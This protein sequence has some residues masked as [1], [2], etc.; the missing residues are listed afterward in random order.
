M[1]NEKKAVK[2]T[3]GLWSGALCLGLE[4]SIECEIMWRQRER[5][6]ERDRDRDRE[7]CAEKSRQSSMEVPTF[8]FTNRT[9][10]SR[11][12]WICSKGANY[13]SHS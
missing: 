9:F 3:G 1:K 6:R 2:K 10:W 7:P 11:K 8:S 4:D 13:V 12:S 5:Q